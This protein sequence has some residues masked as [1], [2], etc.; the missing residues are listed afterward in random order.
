MKQSSSCFVLDSKTAFI[1]YQFKKTERKCKREVKTKESLALKRLQVIL[2]KSFVF[3]LMCF[4][5][6]LLSLRK[7]FTNFIG[8]GHATQ[9][10]PYLQFLKNFNE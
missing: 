9:S 6:A 4:R 10:S 7:R 8:R 3:S 5:G 1:L 2:E